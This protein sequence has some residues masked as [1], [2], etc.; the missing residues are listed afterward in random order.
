MYS[1]NN[2]EVFI[3]THLVMSITEYFKNYVSNHISSECFLYNNRMLLSK[4]I[5]PEQ[6]NLNRDYILARRSERGF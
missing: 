6:Y 4:A 3:L 2:K 5:T 1:D